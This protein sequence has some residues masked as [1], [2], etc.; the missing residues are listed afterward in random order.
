[1]NMQKIDNAE[2]NKEPET[3]Y[4]T[5]M[6]VSRILGENI[7]VRITT[8]GAIFATFGLAVWWASTLQA[9]VRGLQRDISTIRQAVG[10]LDKMSGLENE[11]REIRQYGSSSA[12]KNEKA[13]EELKKAFDLHVA[14]TTT[15]VPHSNPP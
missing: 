14:L 7:L 4:E 10:A 13:I 1:M 15:V 6:P 8:V 9:D 3:G 11:I 5:P 2:E 12:Q